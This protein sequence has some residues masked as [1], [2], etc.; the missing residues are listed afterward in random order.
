LDAEYAKPL[1][2]EK[3]FTNKA[4]I[5]GRKEVVIKPG[6]KEVVFQMG[7]TEGEVE[8]RFDQQKQQTRKIRTHGKGLAVFA[9]MASRLQYLS[10]MDPGGGDIEYPDHPMARI[11]WGDVH[12][13]I[14]R[15]KGFTGMNVRLLTEAEWEFAA[16]AGMPS[17]W[18]FSFGYNRYKEIN[19]YAV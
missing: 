18:P 6:Q 10:V 14:E 11:G 8:S 12:K 9:G 1:D 13:F 16:R 7:S 2:P 4:G 19:D 17:I 3:I 5:S 15:A